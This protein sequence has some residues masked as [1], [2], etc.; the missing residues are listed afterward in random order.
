M[1]FKWFDNQ[2]MLFDISSCSRLVWEKYKILNIP[3]S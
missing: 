2:I 1:E 3:V